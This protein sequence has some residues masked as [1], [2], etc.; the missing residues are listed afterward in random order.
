MRARDNLSTP[1]IADVARRLDAGA[2]RHAD[3]TSADLMRR[4]DALV[5]E[6]E[7]ER[8]RLQTEA[9]IAGVFSSPAGDS[10]RTMLSVVDNFVGG[11]VLRMEAR[12]RAAAAEADAV[13]LATRLHAACV[14]ILGTVRATSPTADLMDNATKAITDAADDLRDVGTGGGIVAVIIAVAVVVVVLA[15][16]K[17]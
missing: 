10:A 14:K 16:R 15:T 3:L 7:R 2:P 5:A 4:V 6:L 8:D 1:R 17:A 13:V 11:T 9:A 12:I